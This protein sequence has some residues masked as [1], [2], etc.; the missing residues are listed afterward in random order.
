MARRPQ[1]AGRLARVE[2]AFKA[3]M[4]LFQLVT[5]RTANMPVKAVLAVLTE[6]MAVV[7]NTDGDHPPLS[8]NLLLLAQADEDTEPSV[9]GRA[10]LQLA[11]RAKETRQ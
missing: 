8:K 6:A 7:H 4:W 9:M 2:A 3:P 11:R 10:A 1:I 5:G